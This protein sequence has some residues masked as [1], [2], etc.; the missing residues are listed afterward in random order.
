VRSVEDRDAIVAALQVFCLITDRGLRIPG[1]D[2]QTDEELLGAAQRV[3][4]RL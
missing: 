3:L 1:R 2:H 4:Q